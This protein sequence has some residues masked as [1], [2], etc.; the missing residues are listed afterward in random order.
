M[1][2]PLEKLNSS[3]IDGPSDAG[4]NNSIFIPHECSSCVY[5]LWIVPYK[6]ARIESWK[7]PTKF[8]MYIVQYLDVEHI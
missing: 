4:M 2:K 3:V 7:F 6:K 1:V 8:N 5:L